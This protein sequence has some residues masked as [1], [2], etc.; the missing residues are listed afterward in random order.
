MNV[1]ESLRDSGQIARP[2]ATGTPRVLLAAA[3]AGFHWSPFLLKFWVF[4]PFCL[5]SQNR[6]ILFSRPPTRPLT[7]KKEGGHIPQDASGAGGTR[8]PKATAMWGVSR[9]LNPT[10]PVAVG[11]VLSLSLAKNQQRPQCWDPR[12]CVATGWLVGRRRKSTLRPHHL[13]LV[14]Q[15]GGAT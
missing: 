4:F 9:A 12:G 6:H 8:K 15:T 11:S 13:R 2:F 5:T 7:G 1:T 3:Q 14:T 10:S